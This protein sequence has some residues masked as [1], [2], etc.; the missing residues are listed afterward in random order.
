MPVSGFDKTQPGNSNIS[1][2]KA[3]NKLYTSQTNKYVLYDHN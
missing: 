1:A 2:Q 3:N